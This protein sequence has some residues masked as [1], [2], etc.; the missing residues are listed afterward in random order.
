MDWQQAIDIYCE[1]TSPAYWAEPINALTNLSFVLAALWSAQTA[2]ARDVRA[3]VVWVLIG[4]AGLIGVGSYLFHTHATAWSALAD[5]VPIWTFVAVF[6]LAAM[7]FIGGMEPRRIALVALGVVAVAGAAALFAGGEGRTGA[8]AP[9]PLNGS[10][11]YAPALVALMVFAVLAWRRRHPA[12]P[13]IAAATGVFLV[14]LAFRTLD[15]DICAAFPP[16]THFLWHLLNGAVIAILL[17]MLIRTG[18]FRAGR[19]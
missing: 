3:P 11:Q 4:L 2:L 16:G 13:W 5:V 6:V 10:G 9:D 1:R 8:R 19:R 18:G 17:Q 12:A 14:S 7:R 15:R